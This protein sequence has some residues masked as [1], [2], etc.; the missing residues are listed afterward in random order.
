[1]VRLQGNFF[2]WDK[3]EEMFGK[4]VL[5]FSAAA[6]LALP[7]WAQQGA[8]LNG[9]WKLD[10]A[11]SD[12]GQFPPPS[13]E[14]D[15]IQIA[16]TSFAQQVTSATQRGDS[17]YTRACTVN[18]KETPLTPDN[19]NAHIGPILLSKILCAW[20]GEALVVTEGALMQGN[21]LTDKLTYSVS[22]DGNTMTLTSHITSPTLNADRK[23]LYERAG[24]S[25][26]SAANGGVAPTAGAMAM[27]HTGGSHPDLSGTW[28]LDI[29]KSDFGQ[30]PPP[31]S[32]VDTIV[33]NEPS[34][35]IAIDQKGGMMGDMNLTEAL[36]TDGQPSSWAGMGGSKVDGTAQW[37]GNTLVIN[38]KSSFQGSDV[39]LKNS[40]TPGADG[41]SLTEVTHVETSM[42]NF[43]ST[44]VYDK[45]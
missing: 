3:E 23:M 43:D 24:D 37:Q 45:Q 27:I 11:K 21:A 30:A 12:F 17:T 20:D 38:A 26:A 42:G 22:S 34:L 10:V 1:M 35:K 14:T 29:A 40:Y 44:T 18:G 28:K 41:K 5:V 9:T 2:L 7:G 4:I 13:S 6:A 25:A 32:E 33:D 19:P 16:G 36:T 31:A 8:R 39:T 15:V